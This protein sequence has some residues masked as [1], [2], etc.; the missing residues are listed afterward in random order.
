VDPTTP[1]PVRV[2]L[3]GGTD[4]FPDDVAA[5]LKDADGG[6]SVERAESADDAL[7][8]V[9]D[10]D[11][12]VTGHEFPGLTGIEFVEAVRDDFPDLPV[13]L[14][15]ER[16]RSAVAGEALAAGATDYVRRGDDPEGYAV[17][18]NR[19]TNA[20][21][22]GSPASGR[23]GPGGANADEDPWDDASGSDDGEAGADES[24]ADESAE[25]AGLE[26]ENESNLLDQIF[27]QVPA[28]IFVKDTEGRHL[29]VSTHLTEDQSESDDD[30]DDLLVGSFTREN[31]LGK[32]DIDI[33]DADHARQAYEN[34]MRVV[35]TGEPILRQEEYADDI[36]EW[37]LTSKVPW[38]GP[39]GEVRG[40][41]GITQ[42]ITERKRAQQE[43]ERQNERLE[44]F[45]SV[46][47]HDLRNPL[48][49]AQGW[50]AEARE[51]SS[52]PHLDRVAD[53]LDRMEELIDDLLALART[54]QPVEETDD[55]DLA[56]MCEG[57]WVTVETAAASLVVEADRTIRA[58]RGRLRQLLENLF[59]NAVEHGSTSNQ[60]E[61]DDAAEGAEEG[62]TV[63]VGMLEDGFYVADDGLGIPEAE[64]EDV[65]ERGYTTARS[66]TGFGLSIVS[67]VADAH[68][69]EVRVTDS[70]TGGARFE[71]TGVEFVERQE[72]GD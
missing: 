66:G 29:K 21:D 25:R 50:V 33:T 53:A 67:E 28:H 35:E 56:V 18:A 47:S 51:E 46:V 58:D 48:N 36:D 42:R 8:W 6:L 16:E 24:G 27:D 11:C 14:Y 1:R 15:T 32:R 45:A 3:V 34:D 38:R 52:D 59:R 4:E 37:D 68:G 26:I 12:L 60:S 54:G 62:V 9:Y 41:I 30:N 7:A 63:T 23:D 19:I 17:L 49:V 64:R 13:F 71:F 72:R 20:V 61:S 65:F 40:L 31:I 55:V 43:L 44:E 39:D 22:R 57:C 10:A 2:L 69:W 70:E 5:A